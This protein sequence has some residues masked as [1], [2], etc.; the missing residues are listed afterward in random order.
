[1][2]L[3]VYFVLCV[4][5]LILNFFHPHHQVII[6]AI[7]KMNLTLLHLPSHVPL[8]L[9]TLLNDM[10]A[11]ITAINKTNAATTHT[12]TINQMDQSPLDSATS[13]SS[14]DGT[15]AIGVPERKRWI[16][17]KTIS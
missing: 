9:T 14:V 17:C 2:T 15:M 5:H 1:M 3:Y 8:F 4:Y 13:G 16:Q 12:T 10:H 11:I 7:T 6:S